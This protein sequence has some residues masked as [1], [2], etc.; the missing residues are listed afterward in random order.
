MAR[1]LI[2][3]RPLI[4][5]TDPKYLAAQMRLYNNNKEIYKENMKIYYQ[6]N[7]ERLKA[8]RRARYAAQKLAKPLSA[9]VD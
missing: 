1:G 9:T 6:K 5:D 3:S 4:K 2:T 7:K 8:N